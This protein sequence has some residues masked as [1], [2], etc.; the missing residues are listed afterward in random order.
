MCMDFT[1]RLVAPF[2]QAQRLRERIELPDLHHA[3]SSW[4]QILGSTFESEV[5]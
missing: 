4:R 1:H 2:F 3:F 5:D